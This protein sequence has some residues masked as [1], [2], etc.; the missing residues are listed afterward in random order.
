M[1][2]FDEIREQG[3]LLFEGIRGSRLHGLDTENSDTDTSGL[4]CCPESWLFGMRLD[5]LHTIESERSDDY[6]DELEKFFTKLSKSNPNALEVLFIPEELRLYYNPILDPLFSIRESLITKACF[7]TF[8]GYAED[9]IRKAKG[10]NKA[11]NTKPQDVKERKSPLHFCNVIEGHKSIPLDHW[12]QE[13]GLKQE[14]CGLVRLP[15]GIELYALYYDWQADKDVSYKTWKK[16]K[17]SGLSWLFR[18]TSEMI[19]YRG[20]LDRNNP[21]TQLRLSSIPEDE[22]KPLCA[23]QFNVNAYTD[24]CQKY[25]RYWDWVKNRNPERY[26]LSEEYG[27]NAKNMCECVRIL[28]MA[29]EMA[30]GKG[31]ILNRRGIDRDFLLSI[32]NHEQTYDEIL[33]Y[34]ESIKKDMLDSF[35]KSTLPEAPDIR[36]LENI[37]IKIRT[38]FYDLRRG[39][40]NPS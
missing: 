15:R 38:D 20:I 24:H 36:E 6:W 25:K 32:K 39:S 35:S 19:L 26:K 11:I 17:G 33:A 22:D 10:Q 7:S 31:V 1:K 34:V 9:Q 13:N 23:F 21:T 18:S 4:F 30:E 27:F 29:K 2:S 16:F 12:L 14:H 37:M 8:A 40:I 28:T 3:Y 5:Y